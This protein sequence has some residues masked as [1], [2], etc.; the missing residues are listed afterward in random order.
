MEV[1]LAP[2][3]SPQRLNLNWQAVD[4]NASSA[5]PLAAPAHASAAPVDLAS[6]SYDARGMHAIDDFSVVQ[7]CDSVCV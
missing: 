4:G 6:A 2:V 5:R 3:G 1:A 7:V